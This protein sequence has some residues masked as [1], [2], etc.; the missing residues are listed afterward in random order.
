MTIDDFLSWHMT[1]T[2][3]TQRENC[4][5]GG[6]GKEKTNCLFL[7]PPHPIPTDWVTCMAWELFRTPSKILD[8]WA[9]GREGRAAGNASKPAKCPPPPLGDLDGSKTELGASPSNYKGRFFVPHPPIHL[10]FL[11]PLISVGDHT[12]VVQKPTFS[13]NTKEIWDLL[14]IHPRFVL[15]SGCESPSLPW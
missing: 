3:Q 11:H 15:P 2:T 7:F 1:K 12:K 5:P 6:G 9:K 10:V 8:L 13:N 14:P 4:L